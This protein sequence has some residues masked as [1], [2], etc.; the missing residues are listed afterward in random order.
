MK[1]ILLKTS[2]AV[3]AFGVVASLVYLIRKRTAA[4]EWYY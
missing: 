2:G 4:P 3:T 1:K